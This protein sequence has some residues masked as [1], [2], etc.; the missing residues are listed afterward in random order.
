MV[1]HYRRR[2]L[3][4]GQRLVGPA[5]ILE[6]TATTWLAPAWTLSVSG[7]GHLLLE[8]AP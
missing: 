4:P 6:P 2:E 8:Q 5:I 1:P 7:Q 3:A